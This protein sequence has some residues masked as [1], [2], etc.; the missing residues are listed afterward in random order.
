MVRI[1]A[2]WDWE[3]KK[4]RNETFFYRKYDGVLSVK[5]P[6]PGIDSFYE[7][8]IILTGCSVSLYA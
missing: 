8:C 3:G 1:Q 7:M 6:G 5:N 2:A 4:K